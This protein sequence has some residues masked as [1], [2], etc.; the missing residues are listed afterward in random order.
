MKAQVLNKYDDD[1]TAP[2]WVDLE[3]VPDPII[4]KSNDV[5]VRIGGAGVCR[6]D[7]HIIEGVWRVA[8][9]PDGNSLLP[10]IMGHE[11]A[12]WIEDVG[13][14]VEGLK[15][16]DPVIVHPKITG[17]TCIACRRGHDMHGE[18][19][20]FPGVDCHGG[21]AEALKTTSRNIVKLPKTLVP[22]EVAAYADAGLT[23]YRAAKKASRH[24]LPGEKCVVIGSGGL[25]HI[26]IQVLRAMCAAEII[27]VDPSD[28]SLSLAETCG[29]EHLVK[30]DGNEVERVL[31][32]TKGKGA[33]AVMDFVAE[34]G[35]T[36]KGLAMTRDMGSYYVIGY[37]EDI[38]VS[39]FEMI[40]T[41]KNII[42]SL[43]GT[44]AEL[45]E[46]MALADRGKVN[47]AVQEYSLDNANQAL[48]DL[49]NRKVKGRGV[50]VP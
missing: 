30:A 32:L 41:E 12:G 46:L 40:T 22:K 20:S 16:G 50:L 11:N 37:G 3:N 2:S 24:L 13:P 44:W 47:L 26:A 35:T 36:A 1:L 8:T 48:Q 42:G 34:H 14:E 10:L 18:N 49:N 38:N 5:I 19:G 28:L 29:A 21:Y 23:A 33:E 25:G 4:E 27:V 39:A 17:G 6:T 45:T 43:V 31:E 9:D 7:L 15:K